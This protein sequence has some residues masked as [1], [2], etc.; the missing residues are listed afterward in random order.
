MSI[1]ETLARVY[2]LDVI[3]VIILVAVAILVG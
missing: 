3:G 2:V 1:S